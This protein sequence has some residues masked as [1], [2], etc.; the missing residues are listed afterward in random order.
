MVTI[1]AGTEMLM[2]VDATPVDVKR[3][4]ADMYRAAGRMRDLLA[5]VSCAT[6]GNRSIAERCEIRELIATAA[7]APFVIRFALTHRNPGYKPR[8]RSCA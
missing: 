6:Y 8:F 4:A 3:L 7:G 2:N 1:F 5:E